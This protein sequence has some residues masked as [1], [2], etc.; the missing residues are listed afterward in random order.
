VE[1]E[2]TARRF[3][4][5]LALGVDIRAL[6]FFELD[7]KTPLKQVK[8]NLNEIP[9]E[10][11]VGVIA[12]AGCP[13][14][15]DPGALLVQEAHRRNLEIIPLP[16]PSSII[17]AMMASGFSG[18]KFCFNGYLPIDKDKRA[19]ALH[20]LESASERWGETHLFMETPYRNDALLTDILQACRDSTLL[21]IASDIGG[22]AQFIA[23]K[24]ISEWKKITFDLHKKPTIFALSSP[25]PDRKFNK[26]KTH[27]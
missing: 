13:G 1:N 15:A 5:A 21:C 12:E 23:T 2:R 3:I 9:P 27:F 25:T 17:L 22:E 14:I 26:R 11:Q 16:G 20:R 19:S 10:S 8:A 4:S 24:S 7:K 18:Q 6:H